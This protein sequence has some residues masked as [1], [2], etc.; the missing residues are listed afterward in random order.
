MHGLGRRRGRYLYRTC[1]ATTW[2]LF[3]RFSIWSFRVWL[4]AEALSPSGNNVLLALFPF[5]WYVYHLRRA[6]GVVSPMSLPGS[7][8]FRFPVDLSGFSWRSWYSKFTGLYHFFFYFKEEIYFADR[9]RRRLL[10]CINNFP[11]A[12]SIKDLIVSLSLCMSLFVRIYQT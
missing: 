3:S 1:R 10:V 4:G 11:A 8:R 5:R 6:C 2:V 7:D 9:G 12:A